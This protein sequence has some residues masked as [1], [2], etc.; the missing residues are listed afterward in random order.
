MNERPFVFRITSFGYEDEANTPLLFRFKVAVKYNENEAKQNNIIE[1][2]DQQNTS[3]SKK[4]E[5]FTGNDKAQPKK[6]EQYFKKK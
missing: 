3:N 2:A 1:S 4:R 5:K 6:K